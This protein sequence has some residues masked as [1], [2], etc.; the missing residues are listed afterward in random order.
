MDKIY[1]NKMAFYGYHGVF[2]EENKLGQRFFVDVILELNLKNAGK[3]DDLNKTVNYQDI[4]EITKKIVE[5]PPKKLVE[6]VAED[7]SEALL[8]TFP[9]IQKCHIKVTK[10]DPPIPGYYDSV[11]IELTRS[12]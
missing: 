4:Y 9:N 12:R 7:I 2:S 3:N 6:S 10:P 1:V 5:G 11:A 8:S